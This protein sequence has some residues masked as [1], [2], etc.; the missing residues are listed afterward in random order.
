ARLFHSPVAPDHRALTDA[1]ATVDVMHGLFERLGSLGVT[2]VHDLT[3]AADPVPPARRR[4]VHLAQTLPTGPGVYLF[5]GP[6]GEIL[7]VGTAKNLRRRVRQYFTSAPDRRRIGEM[8][9]L[10]ARVEVVEC[11]TALE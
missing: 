4:K 3:T 8:V 9:D 1:R 11:P 10:A 6:G 7:Y 5:T 2:H